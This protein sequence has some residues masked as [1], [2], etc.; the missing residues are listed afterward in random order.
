[1]IIESYEVMENGR[2]LLG[3]SGSSLFYSGITSAYLISLWNRGTM[4]ELES[5]IAH[6]GMFD[7]PIGLFLPSALI[8]S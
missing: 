5:L 8:A 4:T 6:A 1:M 2:W 3:S 7:G